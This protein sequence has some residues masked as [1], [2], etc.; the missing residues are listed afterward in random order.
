MAIVTYRKATVER[1]GFLL[2]T[3]GRISIS[4]THVKDFF[5]AQ[6]RPISDQS[7]KTAHGRTRV[8][9]FSFGVLG[10]GAHDNLG[11]LFQFRN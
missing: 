4:F 1:N 9:G 3:K 2:P 11:F 10:L 7:H 8:S 5:Y 6:S